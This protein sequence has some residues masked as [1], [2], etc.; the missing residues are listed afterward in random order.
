M[1]I[2]FSILILFLVLA[3]IATFILVG[4]AIGVAPMLGLT[5]LAMLAG[6]LLLRRQGVVTVNRIRAEIAAGRLPA[7][8]L[9]EG[10]A[11]AIAGLLL[12]LPGF[13]TDAA[14]ILLCIPAFRAAMWRGVSR[15]LEIRGAQRSAI[16]PARGRVV[17]L[18][19]SEYAATP[20]PA[21]TRE[22]EDGARR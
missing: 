5:L 8:P 9:A 13:L 12:I 1:R 16:R 4:D 19:E 22:R 2:P 10:A 21:T 6:A 7:R 20:R 11:F 14:G 3:E 15:R 17:E 18:E